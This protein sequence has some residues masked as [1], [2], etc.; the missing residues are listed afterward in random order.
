MPEQSQN[1]TRHA[2][3]PASHKKEEYKMANV[4][5]IKT[6]DTKK[7]RAKN[8][9][10]QG[11]SVFEDTTTKLCHGEFAIQRKVLRGNEEIVVTEIVNFEHG[12]LQNRKDLG[13]AEYFEQGVLH[14]EDGPA[15]ICDWGNWEEWWH[16]ETLVMIRTTN[17][18]TSDIAQRLI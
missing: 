18:I 9:K 1:T 7:S 6:S 13:D 11:V 8:L 15:V 12:L 10:Y 2:E 4:Y 3:S 16:H 5:E 14:R 17:K